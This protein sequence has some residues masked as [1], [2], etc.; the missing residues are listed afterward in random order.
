MSRSIWL[1]I[2]TFNEAGN[3]ERAIAA[4]RAALAEVAD[5]DPHV[6][7]VDD[8]SP[9][10]TG[11]IA[12]R[13]AAAQPAIEVLHRTVR[14]G[15]GPAYLAGFARAL[16]RGAEL[17]F[18]MDADLSHD[19]ADLPRLIAAIDAGADLALGSRYVDGGAVVEWGLLRR[20]ISRSACLYARTVLG[21]PV[22]D[23]TGGFKCFRR[24]VLETI[25]LSTVRSH[26]YVFQIEL[27][28]RAVR[29][30]FRVVEVPITFRDRERGKSKM[31]TRIAIEAAWRVPQLR[32]RR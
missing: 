14:E 7:I 1:V 3:I 22:R 31:S 19:P 9:D 21:L 17:V 15:L 5:A 4:A 16:E 18:E 26:G 24:A 8:S 13:L 20:L 23:L 27:T 10:G 28:L 2:P 12:D 6:L 29:R 11:E 25:D 32:A 30:G